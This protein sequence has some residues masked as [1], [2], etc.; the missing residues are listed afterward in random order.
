MIYA[1]GPD[2]AE[3]H[4]GAKRGDLG[5][6][7]GGECESCAGFMGIQ[8]AGCELETVQKCRY[9]RGPDL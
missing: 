5:V 1:R 9:P 4:S 7:K 2:E 3:S 6:L 8:Y